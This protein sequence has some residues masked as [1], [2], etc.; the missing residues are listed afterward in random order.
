MMIKHV[1]KVLPSINNTMSVL[2][3]KEKMLRSQ[4]VNAYDVVEPKSVL[5]DMD[6]DANP[7]EIV[8]QIWPNM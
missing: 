7:L 2:V 8:T 4:R 1:R 5:I 6:V 3:A